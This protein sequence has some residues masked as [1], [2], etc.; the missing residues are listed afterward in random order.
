MVFF[1]ERLNKL[2][3]DHEH[4]P[5]KKG[6]WICEMCNFLNFAKNTKCLQCHEKPSKREL[7]P[8][9]WEC[10]SCNYINFRR[11]M[12]CLK[13]DWKRPKASISGDIAADPR[14]NTRR[15]RFEDPGI[16]FVRNSRETDEGHSL[17]R[18]SLEGG[19]NFWCSERDASDDDNDSDS[20]AVSSF[21][22]VDDFPVLGG[23]S[24]IS[25]DPLKSDRWKGEMLRRQRFLR[26]GPDDYEGKMAASRSI[27][28]E[29]D[30]SSDEDEIAGWFKH[31]NGK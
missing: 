28:S 9:E 10:V 31:S 18:K 12:V 13:C 14:V 4:L 25:R 24:A 16:S 11:N 17:P 6:D 26:E 1:Q 5:L 20:G 15:D 22:E 29:L 2:R 7:N 3:E 30:D 27:C 8:G 23:K 21:A 19:A